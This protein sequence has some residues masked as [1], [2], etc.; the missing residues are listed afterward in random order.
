MSARICRTA[1]EAFDAGWNAS[2][3]HG[4]DPASCLACGLT[5][6]EIARVVTLLSGLRLALAGREAA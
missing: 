1:D 5:D 3:D 2:C 4:A 6:S